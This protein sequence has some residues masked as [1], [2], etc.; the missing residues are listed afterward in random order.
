MKITL[1]AALAGLIATTSVA[2]DTDVSVDPLAEASRDRYDMLGDFGEN[3]RLTIDFASRFSV[4]A[5]TNHITTIQYFGLDIH[6]VFTGD[7]G[8]WGT[9]MLQPYLTRFDNAE[10]RPPFVEE[11]DG[12]ELF[13]RQTY[14]NY[15]GLAGG[16]LNFKVG[17]YEIPYGLE[18]IVNTNGTIRDYTHGRNIGVKADWGATVNGTLD[19]LEYEVG[20]S[21]G[22]GNE[23]SSRFDPWLLA[24]RFGT[25]RDE[26]FIF[27]V[28]FAHGDI[29]RPA[30][31]GGTLNRTRIGAD[32]T[33]RD[34]AFTLMGELSIGE[35]EDE[36]VVNAIVEVDWQDPSEAWLVYLQGKYFSQ[37][38]ATRGWDDALQ[39]ALGVRWTPDGK[40][41]F[42]AQWTQDITTFDPTPRDGALVLQ[43]RVRF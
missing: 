41:Y 29:Q 28:S 14:F 3:L 19:A 9:M 4:T 6:K 27:G 22:T 40:W 38:F 15:T 33:W 21:R 36:D 26:N 34:E 18:T 17:H 43:V 11:E 24:G 2:E 25:S 20:L 8:D 10:A 7:N 1:T 23:Y 42:S 32:V 35:D 13:W 30:L 5:D 12:W 31:P 37:D 39:S 16:R